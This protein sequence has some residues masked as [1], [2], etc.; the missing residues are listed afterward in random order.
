MSNTQSTEVPKEAVELAARAEHDL[1]CRE[2]RVEL[3]WFDLTD[4]E[5]QEW[6]DQ[7]RLGLTA[8]APVLVG[9]AR[10][11][12]ADQERQRR[13]EAEQDAE[14]AEAHCA[15]AERQRDEAAQSERQR[16]QEALKQVPI[17]EGNDE[18]WI[19][20]QAALDTLNP[21]GECENCGGTGS[22]I[23]PATPAEGEHDEKCWECNGTGKKPVFH[24]S[25]E[26]TDAHGY[27]RRVAEK[28]GGCASCGS[29]EVGALRK[30][31]ES[32]EVVNE[33]SENWSDEGTAP[34]PTYI[35]GLLQSAFDAA[36]PAVPHP[37]GEQGK[38]T[39]DEDWPEVWVRK[40]TLASPESGWMLVAPGHEQYPGGES[41]ESHHRVR[42]YVP[43][44]D[45][46]EER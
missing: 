42:R 37:S 30:L 46:S 36:F 40:D 1:I 34:H 23:Q 8:A 2:G 44:T 11:Q 13:E 31:L 29:L 27:A 43:A 5:R 6:R 22:Y 24:P 32:D 4:V 15:A 3:S 38:E 17:W 18:R 25:G 9:Q 10:K 16:I 21:S 28:Y 7:V 35:R 39:L 26:E 19:S 12:G 41:P 45:T 20:R 14:R 33:V